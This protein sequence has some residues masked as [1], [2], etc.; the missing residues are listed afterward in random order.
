VGHDNRI[1]V[2][3][4]NELDRAPTDVDLFFHEKIFRNMYAP[5]SGDNPA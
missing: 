1:Q 4:T 2:A 3:S 5:I